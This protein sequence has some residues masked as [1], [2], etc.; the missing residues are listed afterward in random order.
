MKIANLI[1]PASRLLLLVPLALLAM[2]AQ[3]PPAATHAPPA[4]VQSQGFSI[5]AAGPATATG[6]HP[7]DILGLGGA[8]LIPCENLGL[9]CYDEAGAQDDIAGLSFGEDFTEGE[10]PPVQFSVA[11]GARGADGSA[12]RSEADCTPAQ[13]QADVFE[14]ALD[15][16]N[17]QDLDGDGAACA[18][19]EGFGL[20]LTE[21]EESDNVDALERDPCQW[22]DLTCDG[23]PEAAIYLTLAPG[24][25]T[26]TLLGASAADILV[27]GVEF[28]P[29]VWASAADLGLAA[30]D[31]I[32]ALCLHED[33]DGVYSNADQLLFS[34]APGSPTLTTLSAS[35]ADLLRPGLVAVGVPASA[36]GLLTTDDVDALTC[37]QTFVFSD[38]YLPLVDR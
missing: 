2:T 27:S 16:T 7:A 23:T 31:H 1:H 36:L 4:A 38:L 14:T 32:D 33:G 6:V 25:P 8:P 12:V 9:L 3:Q 15:N 24:S 28:V 19:G 37:S 30:T 13:P 29:M 18:S 26:L 20:S 5:T 34:L 17:L 11:A 21:A 35:P 10:L 22:V